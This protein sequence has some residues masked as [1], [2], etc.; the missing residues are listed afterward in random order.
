[1]EIVGNLFHTDEEHAPALEA[2]LGD[3]LNYVVVT[4]LEEAV[5]ASELLK[6]HEQGRATF[7][8]LNELKE[9]YESEKHSILS[10]VETEPSCRP[11]AELLLGSTL[12]T[13]DVFQARRLLQDRG[14]AAVTKDGEL[15]TAHKFLRSGSKNNQAGV[16]LGLK[17]KLDKL[18]SEL[19]NRRKELELK[20]KQ[21][22]KLEAQRNA[23]D[24]ESLRLQYR[25]TEQE[26]RK[27]EQQ[28][29][30]I[31]SGI[32]VYQKNIEDLKNRRSSL[33][34]SED[35]AREELK[36]LS[37]EQSKLRQEIDDLEQQ[38]SVKKEALQ[39]LEEERTIAQN[40]FNSAQLQHQDVRN[41]A[42]NLERDVKRAES[43]ISSITER[44]ESREE[45]SGQSRKRIEEY[46][47]QIGEIEDRL[48]E[49]KEE[50]TGAEQLAKR[51]EEACSTQRGTIHELE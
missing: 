28:Q 31:Q 6:R 35:T 36:T 25:E 46:K 18:E 37:P 17:D 44:L 32:Q 20:Q 49:K 40:R 15:I 5:R 10:V 13:E 3:A 19:G 33:A 34:A 1:M 24:L 50:K 45:L 14:S 47:K 48:A 30:R 12:L 7:I 27:W 23:L 26:L 38:Q 29:S 2:A 22:E 8:P 51:V 39:N 9:S 41:K 42:D 4:N 16:H 21:L 43:G 11:L